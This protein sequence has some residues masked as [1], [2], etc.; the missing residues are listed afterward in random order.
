MAKKYG[1]NFLNEI[2]EKLNDI[3]DYSNHYKDEKTLTE[4][5]EILRPLIKTLSKKG[6]KSSLISELFINNGIEANQQYLQKLIQKTLSSNKKQKKQISSSN[7][8]NEITIDKKEESKKNN[9]KLNNKN[10]NIKSSSENSF[11]VS[12][13]SEDL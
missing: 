8:N 12:D 4:S 11:T 13:D 1:I 2:S 3:P 5:I 10:A 9:S 7:S 6:Y